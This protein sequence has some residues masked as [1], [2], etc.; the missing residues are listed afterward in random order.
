MPSSLKG[1]V[2]LVTGASRGLGAELAI[3]LAERGAD[4]VIC[5]RSVNSN[6]NSEYTGTLEETAERVRGLNGKAIVVQ[7]D[8]SEEQDI[9]ALVRAA[10][11]AFGGVDFLINN[12]AY[13]S[14]D[15]RVGFLSLT[16]EAWRRQFAVNVTAPFI[17]CQSFAPLMRDRGGGVII[18]LTSSMAREEHAGIPGSGSTPGVGYPVSK[19]ALNR[20]GL[21]LC[22]ELRPYNVAIVTVEPGSFISERIQQM[23]SR[24]GMDMSRRHSIHVPVTTILHLLGCANPM[25]YS[26]QL[27]VA[28]DFAREHRLV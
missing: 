18:N 22:K 4:L 1:K 7:A 15:V 17:L 19:A 28:K 10:Q 2:A 27:I 11:S 8:L 6:P 24:R 9:D 20:M 3:R 21:A 5:G 25:A 23:A 13:L 14:D 16:R 26:G 12:A